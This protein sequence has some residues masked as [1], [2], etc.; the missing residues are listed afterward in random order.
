MAIDVKTSRAYLRTRAEQEFQAKER[1]RQT[2]LG[3]LRAAVRSIM[4]HF[5]H[6]RRVYLFGSAVRP[7]RLRVTSDLDVAVEG[8]LGA[9]EYFALW[10]ELERAVHDWP[11]DLVDLDRRGVYF[12]ARVRETG[13]LTYERGDSNIG[14]FL[15]FLDDLSQAEQ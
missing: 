9:E 14:Q 4:P 7:G 2:A 13:E 10:R 5:P 1:E 3:V 11:I 15:A 12:A 6:A 8:L